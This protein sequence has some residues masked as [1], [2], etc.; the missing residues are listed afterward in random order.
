[1]TC[2]TPFPSHPA[3]E[4]CRADMDAALRVLRDAIALGG[5]VLVC[6]NGGSASDSEHIVGELMKGFNLKRP[7]SADQTAALEAANPG[8][9]VALAAK[10]QGTIAA[11]SLVSQTGLITAIANDTDANMI[12]AQQ[13]LGIGQRGDVLLAL[14]TSGN[15]R[16]VVAAAKVARAFG[17]KVVA[18]TGE[19]GG[20]LAPLAD[21][22]IRV[23]ATHVAAIQELH[24]PV[25]HW[26]CARLEEDFFGEA[27]RPAGL[28]DPIG[29]IVFDF[30][31]VFTDNKVYT[32]Q[33]GTELVA[34]DRADGLGLDR[35]RDLAVPMMILSTETNPVVAARARKL[36][37]PVE[38]S[39]GDKAAWLKDHL[40]AKGIDPA[41]VIYMGNDLNDLA[42][43]GLVGFTVAPADAHPEIRKIASLVLT[44]EGGRGAVRELSD[45]ISRQAKV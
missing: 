28:P 32:A 42:A 40:A 3:L 10:L 23:P 2:A 1:M 26:L 35:L 4:V 44:R 24:L 31:G 41:T 19:G 18:L 34:C 9:G 22:A 33:D 39:C 6:G 43:M 37:L 25:Y 29:L 30:D 17:I 14:S 16:N 15:S 45:F 27:A 5:K 20:V 36:K 12:F 8:E 21:V 13:V 7:L 11:V 38:Q